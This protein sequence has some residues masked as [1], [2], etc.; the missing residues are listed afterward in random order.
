MLL[1]GDK[2]QFFDTAVAIFIVAVAAVFLIKRLFNSSQCSGC[3]CD[4][5]D[6]G[7]KKVNMGVTVL[8][9]GHESVSCC[10][11]NG[12]QAAQ[13]NCSGCKCSGE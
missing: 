5:Q 1:R 3:S 4:C 6:G 13:Y 8:P 12:G 11:Q 7:V 10:G 9:A 2:M